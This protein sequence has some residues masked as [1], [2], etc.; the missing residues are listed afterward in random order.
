MR[1]GCGWFCAP[2]P[3]GRQDHQITCSHSADDPRGGVSPPLSA[4]AWPSDITKP[5]FL[6]ATSPRCEGVLALVCASRQLAAVPT[7]R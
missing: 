6:A 3:P 4:P 5:L 7:P 2:A 1:A